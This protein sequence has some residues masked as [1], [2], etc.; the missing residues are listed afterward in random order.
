MTDN[1]SCDRWELSDIVKCDSWLVFRISG[2]LEVSSLPAGLGSHFSLLV[3]VLCM[4]LELV[5]ASNSSFEGVAV[6]GCTSPLLQ[7]R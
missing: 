5:A 6:Q 4:T 2:S 1:S 7:R 3:S